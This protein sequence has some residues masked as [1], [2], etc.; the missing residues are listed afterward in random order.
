M[1][2]T[3]SL[4]SNTATLVTSDVGRNAA[5]RLTPLEED[6]IPAAERPRMEVTNR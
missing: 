4:D 2:P 6:E 5:T 3:T 1:T